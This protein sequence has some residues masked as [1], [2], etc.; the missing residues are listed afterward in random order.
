MAELQHLSYSSIAAYVSCPHA[1]RLKY[2]E[3]VPTLPTPALVFGSAFHAAA[4]KYIAADEKP[5]PG[6]IWPEAWRA[7]TEQ[8]IAWN[9]ELPEQLSNQGLQMLSHADVRA[10]LDT[11]A[12]MVDENGMPVIEKR[13]ELRI[14]GVPIPVIGFVDI[15]LARGSPADLKTSARSWTQGKADLEMQPACYLA[16]LNQTGY[17][18]NPEM[19]FTYIVFVKTKTPQVQVLKTHRAGANLFWLFWMIRQVWHGIESGS[20]PPNPG[21]WLCAPGTCSYWGI[22]RGRR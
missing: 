2:M 11:L 22:C 14:P 8:E 20:F 9:G 13:V 6:A 12:P 7:A 15:I 16:A 19:A 5:D 1:W 4:E 21:S 3:K 10:A 17:R 18:Q